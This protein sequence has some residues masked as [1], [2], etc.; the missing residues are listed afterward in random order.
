MSIVPREVVGR[1]VLTREEGQS[2]WVGDEIL[3]TVSRIDRGQVKITIDAP[4]EL[5]VDRD[6]VRQRR[7]NNWVKE[8][9]K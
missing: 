7:L 5:I 4:N 2:I 3:I 6:E 1:L 8:L 9:I